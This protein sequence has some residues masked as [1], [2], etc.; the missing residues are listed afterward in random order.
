MACK[1][2]E[3]N[4]PRN[5]NRDAKYSVRLDAGRY[6]VGLVYQTDFGERWYP[7]VEGHESLVNMVNQAKLEHTGFQGGA[8]YINEYKQVLVPTTTQREYRYIGKYH[9]TIS[10]Q[11]EGNILS[12]NAVNLNGEP[13]Q[14]GD[15]WVGPH[16]GIPYVL[17][18]GARDIYYDLEPRPRVR[19]R[20]NLSD[21]RSEN[22]VG[23]LC[24]Q[25]ARVKGYAGGRFYINEFQQLFTPITEGHYVDYLYIGPLDDLRNWF[26]EPHS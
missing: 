13:L 4:S 1:R 5:V 22:V 26:P 20:V 16:P 11:F 15:Q 9:E 23:A 7:V 8:F 6:V 24:A 17:A 2:F 12:G 25:I 14:P 21:F 19:R 18:A 3:G 10:F